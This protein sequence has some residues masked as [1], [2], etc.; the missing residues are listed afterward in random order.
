MGPER[1]EAGGLDAIVEGE[2]KERGHVDV[3]CSI[4]LPSRWCPST[5]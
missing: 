4:D 5:V 1:T 2:F 3:P